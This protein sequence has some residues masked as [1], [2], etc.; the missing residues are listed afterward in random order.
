MHSRRHA[1]HP[2]TP[3]RLSLLPLLS[4]ARSS[5]PQVNPDLLSYQLAAAGLHL[6]LRPAS[7]VMPGAAPSLAD[8]AALLQATA[9]QQSL[10]L[11][12]VQV[13]R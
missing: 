13:R 12:Q 3:S 5:L 7:S 11:G 1:L 4:P 9:L 2:L 10:G 6:P 8:Q